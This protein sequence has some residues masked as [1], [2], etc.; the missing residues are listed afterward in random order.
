MSKFTLYMIIYVC[1]LLEFELLVLFEKFR[2]NCEN[3]S[4]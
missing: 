4:F 1:I 2:W 3:M